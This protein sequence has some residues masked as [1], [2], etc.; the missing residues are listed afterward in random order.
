VLRLLGR[1]GPPAACTAH[2]ELLRALHGVKRSL[3]S[4]PPGTPSYPRP[5]TRE[6]AGMA[7][8]A[9]AE[10]LLVLYGAASFPLFLEAL[11]APQP[12]VNSTAIAALGR[13][14]DVRALSHLQLLANN[15][16]HPLC[17]AAV[18]TIALIKRTNPEMM[19]LLRGSSASEAQT[20]T[21]LRPSSESSAATSPAL[22]LRPSSQGGESP[23][24]QQT[25]S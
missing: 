14:G 24:Q 2:N 10:T 21:L 1:L 4:V 11:Y 8:A 19:T 23:V 9:A 13:L 12:E 15:A 7:R 20:E 25:G 22:L 3:V 17:P 5:E 18:E 16:A 6:V